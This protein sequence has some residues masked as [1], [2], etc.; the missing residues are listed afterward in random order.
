MG[1]IVHSPGPL[2]GRTNFVLLVVPTVLGLCYLVA[3]LPQGIKLLNIQLL[4]L[5]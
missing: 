5:F 2:P 1:R 3:L 4:D